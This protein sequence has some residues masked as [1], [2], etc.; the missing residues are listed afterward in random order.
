MVA[1]IDDEVTLPRCCRTTS[2]RSPMARGKASVTPIVRTRVTAVTTTSNRSGLNTSTAS[3]KG[4]F[5]GVAAV[6]VS[7]V[8]GVVASTNVSAVAAAALGEVE[9]RD[10]RRQWRDG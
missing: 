4:S 6:V 2:K 5:L 3:C 7:E 10:R 1:A 9:N 8:F